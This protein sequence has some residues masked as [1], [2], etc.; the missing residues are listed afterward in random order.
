MIVRG[1]VEIQRFRNLCESIIQHVKLLFIH[2][3]KPAGSSKKAL[4]SN[5]TISDCW[6]GIIFLNYP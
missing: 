4:A 3:I 5:S 1:R 2:K 6:W